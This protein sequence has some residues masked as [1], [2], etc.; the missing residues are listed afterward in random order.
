MVRNY[1][2]KTERTKM[3]E[4][5]IEKAINEIVKDKVSVRE[6]AMKYNIPKSTLCNR[7]KR[8]SENKIE[9]V[10]NINYKF[11]S[12]Y[13]SQQIFTAEQE[14]LLRNYLIPCSQL[15]YGLKYAN[16]RTFTYQDANHLEISIPSN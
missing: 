4:E 1:K 13:T 6:A 5:N 11:Q 14:L 10:T 15:N 12:K 9:C 16:T 8:V 3:A 2:P 7:L